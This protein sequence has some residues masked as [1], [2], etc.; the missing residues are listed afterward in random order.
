MTK[1]VFVGILTFFLTTDPAFAIRYAMIVT[2]NH[3]WSSEKTLQYANHD[4]KRIEEVLVSYSNY[5][6]NR[7]FR[8]TDASPHAIKTTIEKIKTLRSQDHRIKGDTFFF[9]YSGHS[10]EK[11][12]HLGQE[13][14]TYKELKTLIKSL[15]FDIRIAL[16]DSCKSGSFTQLKGASQTSSFKIDI[17]PSNTNIKGDVYISSAS[18]SENAQESKRLKG[19]FFTNH[20]VSGLRGAA[21]SDHD[22]AIT[23]TEL[24]QFAYQRTISQ[25]SS[26][27]GGIQHP[28]YAMDLKGRGKLVLARP[29][30]A[31]SCVLL[32]SDLADYPNLIIEKKSQRVIAEI[33]PPRDQSLIRVGLSEG[34][35][36]IRR[37]TP[38]GVFQQNLTLY[39][40]ECHRV[41]ASRMRPIKV[42]RTRAKGQGDNEEIYGLSAAYR[43]EFLYQN[44]TPNH[45]IDLSF[46]LPL[47]KALTARFIF[48]Y[49]ENY[50]DSEQTN[51]EYQFS[52]AVTWRFKVKKGIAAIGPLIGYGLLYHKD[53]GV[54]YDYTYTYHTINA[55]LVARWEYPIAFIKL[56]GEMNGGYMRV[57]ESASTSHHQPRFGLSS[58][59]SFH[60]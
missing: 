13:S 47:V 35:Y 6:K 37:K 19:S 39:K 48:S 36:I 4:G 22:G 10:G 25:T 2:N 26:T 51:W 32:G 18:A 50:G 9:Y 57:I 3:G 17:E 45:F 34:S 23:L 44:L 14:F 43:Y 60:W 28:S 8:I 56:F 40:G 15:P 20:I 58:G 53:L 30:Q 27:Q 5:P 11:G 38:Q 29:R 1:A 49:G 41:K 46:Y 31:P 42:E 52:L 54:T 7:I 33:P 59:I 12:L 24:Y 16:I 55:A 21:D